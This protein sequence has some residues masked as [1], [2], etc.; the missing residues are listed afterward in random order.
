MGLSCW[1]YWVGVKKPAPPP[2]VGPQRAE[3]QFS[4]EDA[5]QREG[6]HG[7][8]PQPYTAPEGA[9]GRGRVLATDDFGRRPPAAGAYRR[10]RVRRAGAIMAMLLGARSTS[11]THQTASWQTT[12]FAELVDR[13]FR[14]GFT[15]HPHV[16]E[17][18]AWTVLTVVAVCR[19]LRRAFARA[20]ASHARLSALWRSDLRRLAFC[21]AELS[22][23]LPAGG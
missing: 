18:L 23:D 10:R 3:R 11:A 6:K 2:R 21:C 20:E 1:V 8:W 15:T 9:F 14:R 12:L 22:G 4:V 13:D 5:C 19:D 7:A 17:A 16:T